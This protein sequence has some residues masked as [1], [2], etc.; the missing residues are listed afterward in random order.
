MTLRSK[1]KY[2]EDIDPK[3]VKQ[4]LKK[5]D[6][7]LVSILA[8]RFLELGEMDDVVVIRDD[9][10]GLRRATNIRWRTGDWHVNAGHEWGYS[11]AGPT[12]FARNVLF[13]FTQDEKFATEHQLEFREL[14]VKTLPEAGGRINKED[15]LQFVKNKKKS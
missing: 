9:E 10:Y 15:V 2:I 6:G 1:N 13:Q 8:P 3:I 14:F 4:V 7:K 12:D 5:V 11:G